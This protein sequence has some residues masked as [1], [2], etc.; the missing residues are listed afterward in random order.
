MAEH[1]SEFEPIGCGGHKSATSCS[2]LY[3]TVA[4]SGLPESVCFA[5]AASGLP[6]SVQYSAVA[7]CTV[8]YSHSTVPHR[9]S[10]R[11]CF[12]AIAESISHGRWG[13][14][15][16]VA[17]CILQ[18]STI[19]YINVVLALLLLLLPLPS[20]EDGGGEMRGSGGG[21]RG[22]E[23][24]EGCVLALQRRRQRMGRRRGGK[25]RVA[26]D[27]TVVRDAMQYSTV[28]Y[29]MSDR[30]ERERVRCGAP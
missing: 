26:S 14:H 10:H 20:G 25:R 27:S 22:R 7:Y 5:M 13:I 24:K 11:R 9:G 12:V 16:T 19:Q 18:H 30:R 8:Q 23:E 4:A 1:T 28:Q 29:S 3:S 17:Q 21:G 2:A 6:E 15:S